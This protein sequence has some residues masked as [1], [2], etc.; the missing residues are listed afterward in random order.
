[1][2]AKRHQSNHTVSGV[3]V[4]RSAAFSQFAYCEYQHCRRAYDGDYIPYQR[5]NVRRWLLNIR[6]DIYR[7][8]GEYFRIGDQEKS[9][10]FPLFPIGKNDNFITLS[11]GRCVTAGLLD[12]ITQTR[13]GFV[14]HSRWKSDIAHHADGARVSRNY[15]GVARLQFQIVN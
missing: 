13:A 2:A 6:R 15:Q 11:R 5:P 1:M 8:A 14:R 4:V 12:V 10:L 3:I 9:G 7:G